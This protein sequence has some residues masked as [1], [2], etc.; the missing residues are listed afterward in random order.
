MPY[1]EVAFVERAYAAYGGV[2]IAVLLLWLW[3]V[4][5]VIPDF[6]DTVGAGLC[7]AGAALL[8][9]GPRPL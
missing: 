3:A 5:R 7:L 1:S 9:W 6:W 4:E 8:L 2:Y